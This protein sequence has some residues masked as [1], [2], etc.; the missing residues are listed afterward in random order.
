MDSNFAK[1]LDQLKKFITNQAVEAQFFSSKTYQVHDPSMKKKQEMTSSKEG[2]FGKLKAFFKATR[3]HCGYFIHT[4][5][6]FSIKIQF[7]IVKHIFR[8]AIF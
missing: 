1:L 7:K 3:V 8:F 5:D 2:K 6:I 4:K